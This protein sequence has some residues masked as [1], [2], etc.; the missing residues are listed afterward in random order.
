[1]P[2]DSPKIKLDFDAKWRFFL[3]HQFWPHFRAKIQKWPYLG[4]GWTDFK[5]FLDVSPFTQCGHMTIK[6]PQK[7]DLYGPPSLNLSYN[8]C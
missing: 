2:N 8:I 7:S 6:L 1:M 4:N 5:F 3:S